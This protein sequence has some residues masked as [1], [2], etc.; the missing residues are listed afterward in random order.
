MNFDLGSGP[1]KFYPGHL[2]LA[3]TRMSCQLLKLNDTLISATLDD[4][5]GWIWLWRIPK[6]LVYHLW[7]CVCCA[8][9]IW[10]D[11]PPLPLLPN[12]SSAHLFLSDIFSWWLLGQ[13]VFLCIF[14]HFL[15]VP[16]ERS[17]CDVLLICKPKIVVQWMKQQCIT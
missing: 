11:Q 7:H 5:D 12:V 10:Q 17:Q 15:Q 16:K 9:R 4:D 1:P 2:K 14:L 13:N 8:L 3:V 6:H